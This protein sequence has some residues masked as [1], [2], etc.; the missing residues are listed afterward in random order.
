MIDY[1]I[2]ACIEYDE[3]HRLISHINQVR[4]EED[5][6]YVVLDKTNTNID[7]ENLLKEYDITYK[8]AQWNSMKESFDILKNLGSNET[9][10]GM[11]PDELPS[12]DLLNFAMYEFEHTTYD[13]IAVPRINIFSDL[14]PENVQKMYTGNRE[15][16]Y[17]LKE[18]INE[19]GWHCWPDYQIRI[20][21][22]NIPITWGSNL[23]SGPTG[24]KNLGVLP[25]DPRFALTHIKTI[26]HQ[27]RILKNQDAKGYY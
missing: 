10:F 27:E 23:H 21:Q 12:L 14:T 25:A 7:M 16:D 18:P 6:I 1:Q 8:V 3:L 5:Q 17:L 9:I 20:H 24:F 13:A 2:T 11:C 15:Q 19:Y 26:S 22:R 4:R